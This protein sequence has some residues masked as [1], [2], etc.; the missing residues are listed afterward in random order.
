MTGMLR[1]FV[2]AVLGGTLGL[3]SLSAGAQPAAWPTKPVR[4]IVPFAP[5]GPG[6]VTGRLIAQKL[7]ERWGQQ[8]VVDNKAGANTVIGAV[9]AARAA[10]DGY[11][12]FQP[13]NST[14]TINQFAMSK[15][16]YDPLRDFTHIGVMASVPLLVVVNDTMPAK[17][18]PELIA[19]ARSKPGT[20]TVG[21]GN[22]GQ[23]LAVERFVR[24]SGAQI[25]YIPYK[26]GADVTKGLL[27]GEIQVGFDGV[28]AY[29]PFLKS[30]RLRALATNSPKRISLLPDVPTL[31]ELGLKNSEAPVWHALVGPAGLPPEIKAKIARDVQAVLAM[32][33]VQERLAS[34]GMEPSW[35]GSDE[36]VQLIKSESAVMGPIVKDLGIKMD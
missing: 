4:L 20:V 22:V 3:G 21:G 24:D 29:P 19:L 7:S 31:A 25:S 13:M 23:Q 33:D 26:S 15:P 32:P 12:L 27:S 9:E 8:V 6:D 10:P 17:T 36:F 18:M 28:P 11:T 16:P 30:G 35:M 1:I 34:L 14:L 5:G 2:A